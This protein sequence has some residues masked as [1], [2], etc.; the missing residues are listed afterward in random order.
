MVTLGYHGLHIRSILCRIFLHTSRLDSTQT[1]TEC[2]I[3]HMFGGGG[4]SIQLNQHTH[5][6]SPLYLKDVCL[7]FFI[8]SYGIFLFGKGNCEKPLVK[9][10]FIYE[11][12]VEMG[13]SLKP[14]ADSL[15]FACITL[16]VGAVIVPA[17]GYIGGPWRETAHGQKVLQGDTLDAN[18]RDAFCGWCSESRLGY[19]IINIYE[20]GFSLCGLST[21][22][23]IASSFGCFA[24]EP[25][26][27]NKIYATP[28]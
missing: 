6:H 11:S 10:D 14:C 23:G 21:T 12:R 13:K 24:P 1:H 25:L 3:C 7:I 27:S 8:F 17:V 9:H 15:R 4:L 26:W 22:T 20:I 2:K 16:T 5:S 28:F 18:C 19:F